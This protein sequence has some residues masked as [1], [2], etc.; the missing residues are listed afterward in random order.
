MLIRTRSR[1]SKQAAHL[2]PPPELWHFNM[3]ETDIARVEQGLLAAGQCPHIFHL[4]ERP[5]LS[6]LSP[7]RLQR[8]LKACTNVKVKRL[9]LFFADRH[10]H[11]W[12]KHL[13]KDAVDIGS[14]K[15]VLVKGGK[16][17]KRYHITVP[18]DLDGVS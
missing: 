5:C 7:R 17:D 11:A 9:F 15:R 8:L 6:S 16:L 14:G 3:E 10:Q 1:V 12:L 4:Q 18:G 13:D 2:G